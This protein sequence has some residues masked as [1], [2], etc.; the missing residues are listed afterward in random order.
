VDRRRYAH[1]P[2]RARPR[3]AL[4]RIGEIVKARVLDQEGGWRGAALLRTISALPPCAD[5]SA[6]RRPPWQI[7]V[8]NRLCRTLGTQ[9]ATRVALSP[10]SQ[11]EFPLSDLFW[12]RLMLRGFEHEAGIRLVL[13]R[14]AGRP[15]AFI[16]G[17]A[18]IGYWSV[19]ASESADTEVVAVEPMHATFR[20]LAANCRL[21]ADRFRCVRAA[22]TDRE[23]DT[24]SL[25]QNADRHEGAHVSAGTDG[26]AAVDTASTTTIDALVREHVSDSRPIVLKLDVEGQEINALRGAEATLARQPLIIY[27]DH[28]KDPRSTVSEYVLGTLDYRCFHVDHTGRAHAISSLEE[29]VRLKVNATYGYDLFAAAR[30]SEFELLLDSMQG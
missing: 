6:S 2:C 9:H 15:F 8:M 24:V 22:I 17:G 18:N 1:D 28:G 7:R 20:R 11:L 4:D 13:E 23:G 5:M 19:L 27:E 3:G 14:L 26:T 16:D 30:G 12:M 10:S 25:T 21:N 29:V